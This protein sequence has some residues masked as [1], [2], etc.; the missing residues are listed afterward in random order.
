MEW[1]LA[2]NLRCPVYTIR[3][4][5]LGILTAESVILNAKQPKS[6]GHDGNINYVA[7]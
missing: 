4:K 7:N 3:D 2:D 1:W 5:E 6:Y